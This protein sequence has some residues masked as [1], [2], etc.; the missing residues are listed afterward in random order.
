MAHQSKTVP[1]RSEVRLVVAGQSVRAT[2]HG[3]ALWLRADQIADVL[4]FKE[5]GNVMR[6]YRRNASEFRAIGVA[7][8]VLADSASVG[9][10]RLVTCFA[11]RALVHFACLARTH[12]ARAFRLALSERA[13]AV[14]A[15]RVRDAVTA[16]ALA[17]AEEV[18][19]DAFARIEPLRDAA[20]GEAR[21]ALTGALD[22]IDEQVVAL[23]VLA[24]GGARAVAGL[25]S[26]RQ[27]IDGMA[28]LFGAT[29][30]R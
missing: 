29:G 7:E 9:C 14:A 25:P 1:A 28:A 20:R 21:A 2:P 18:L 8:I 15:K 26:R 27:G 3:G 6:I 19:M 17:G 12:K 24:R 5:A 13:E 22:G 4:G 16:G 10:G 11:P 23:D 30:G